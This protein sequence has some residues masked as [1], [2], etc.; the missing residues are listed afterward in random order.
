MR[1]DSPRQ[2]P[3]ASNPRAARTGA[4]TAP[5]ATPKQT[6]EPEASTVAPGR[7][8]SP[9]AQ[10]RVHAPIQRSGHESVDR[11]EA[12]PP[13]APGAEPPARPGRGLRIAGWTAMGLGVAL[14]GMM[15][16]IGLAPAA[17]VIPLASLMLQAGGAEPLGD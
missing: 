1:L 2:T 5:R 13:L 14:M 6:P 10:A 11:L 17:V 7:L 16:V 3:D 12:A 15:P 9:R 8:A 4:R